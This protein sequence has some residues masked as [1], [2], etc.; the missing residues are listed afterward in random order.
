LEDPLAEEFLRACTKANPSWSADKGQQD[1]LAFTPEPV[2]C[3]VGRLS[4]ETSFFIKAPAELVALFCRQREE[5]AGAPCVLPESKSRKPASFYA[6][7]RTIQM[8]RPNCKWASAST[9]EG[10]KLS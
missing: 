7:Q 5:P 2:R 6:A 9:G 10:Q 1:K 4:I 3:L 8:V